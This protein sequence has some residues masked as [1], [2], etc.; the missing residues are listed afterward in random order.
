MHE[1]VIVG[2][3]C[4]GASTALHLA[5]QGHRVLLVDQTRFPSDVRLSTHLIWH[6]GVDLLDDGATR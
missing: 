5:R 1:V 3:R 4:G 6:A 2:A